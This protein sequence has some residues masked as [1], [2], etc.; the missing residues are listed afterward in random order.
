MIFSQ[1]ADDCSV[2]TETERPQASGIGDVMLSV[3][4]PASPNCR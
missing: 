4:E 2:S 1:S 3:I